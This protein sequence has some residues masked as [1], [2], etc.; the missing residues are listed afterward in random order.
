MQTRLAHKTELHMTLT[1]MYLPAY[2]GLS[3]LV[4]QV[5]VL[6]L[7]PCLSLSV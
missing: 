5:L 7:F 6:W 3:V 1:H 4:M 2:V